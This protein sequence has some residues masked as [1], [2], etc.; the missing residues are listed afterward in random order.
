MKL[1]KQD[2]AWLE[3]QFP[4]LLYDSEAQQ[5]SGMLG[6]CAAYE[7]SSGKLHLTTRLAIETCPPFYAM[8]SKCP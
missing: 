6:F 8:L 7:R 1:G 3:S 4:S 2:I 5:I